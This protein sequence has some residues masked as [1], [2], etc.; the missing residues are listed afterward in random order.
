MTALA[1]VLLGPAIIAAYDAVYA[2]IQK[3]QKETETNDEQ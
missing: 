3:R 2:A 1:A